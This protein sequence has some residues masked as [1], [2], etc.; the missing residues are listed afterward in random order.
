[1]THKKQHSE[2]AIPLGIKWVRF[3]HGV[4]ECCGLLREDDAV[5]VGSCRSAWGLETPVGTLDV[6]VSARSVP[7]ALPAL[8]AHSLCRTGTFHAGHSLRAGTSHQQAVL[9]S[10]AGAGVDLVLSPS[11]RL[12]AI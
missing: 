5:C 7:T 4:Q 8:T 3:Q 9:M 10:T 11:S 12:G 2:C 6:A 1:M